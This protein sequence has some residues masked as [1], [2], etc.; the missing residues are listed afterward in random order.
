MR[1]WYEYSKTCV[2]LPL[3]KRPQIGYQD[4][5]SLNASQKYLQYIR[6][7]LSF[8]LSLSSLFCLFLSGRFVSIDQLTYIKAIYT[9]SYPVHEV[10]SLVFGL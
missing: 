7:S 2:N 10:I 6:P 5:L 9:H 8:H 4:Q 1:K 3:S